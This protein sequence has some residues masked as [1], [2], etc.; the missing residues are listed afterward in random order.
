MSI[1]DEI[2]NLKSTGEEPFQ[3]YRNR[4]REL[5]T[6]SQKELIRDGKIA[7]RFHIGRLNMFVYDP[8]YKNKLP[9]YD[10]FPLVLPIERYDNGFLGLNFHYLPYAL[11][12]RLLDRLEKFTRGSK[13]DARILADYNGLKNVGLVKPT[14]KRYLTQKVR[15]RFRRIDSEDFL[16]A[17]MLPVQRFRKSNVNKVWSDSRKMI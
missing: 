8:K 16:T 2:R 7:G 10:T 3:W 17:L 6:P 5:G 15:S 4:I 14:L 11:R 9:Y 13:D 1:F 12:A